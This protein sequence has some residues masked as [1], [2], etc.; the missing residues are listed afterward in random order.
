VR[1][2]ASK[3]ML[4]DSLFT[5]PVIRLMA[6][7]GMIPEKLPKYLVLIRWGTFRLDLVGRLQIIAA[8]TL[9]AAI[10]GLRIFLL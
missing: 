5:S 10:V 2:H 6:R 7:C 8:A 9:I 3:N 4:S 1:C